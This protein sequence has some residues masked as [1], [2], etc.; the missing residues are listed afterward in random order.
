MGDMRVCCRIILK[1]VLE[2]FTT[3][4]KLFLRVILRR[5]K[6]KALEGILTEK[7]KIGGR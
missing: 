7:I 6:F 3:R 2:K 5:I 1:K 4:E